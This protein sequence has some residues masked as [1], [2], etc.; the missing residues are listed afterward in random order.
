MR[1]RVIDEEELLL[2]SIVGL[3]IFDGG[4]SEE[5]AAHLAK[6]NHSFI[7]EYMLEAQDEAI[8]MIA[9]KERHRRKYGHEQ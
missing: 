7:L 3:R 5:K 6:L 1:L 4:M 9:I 2:D 8:Y